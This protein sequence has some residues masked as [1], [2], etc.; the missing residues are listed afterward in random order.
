MGIK[1]KYSWNIQKNE[2]EEIEKINTTNN[3]NYVKY[4]DEKIIKEESKREV[5][6]K[7]KYIQ[8]C[9]TYLMP[10][11]ILS[12]VIIFISFLYIE[13]KYIDL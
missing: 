5:D 9:I 13:I 11:I 7:S 10:L 4:I 2:F 3:F 6:Y 12:I 8:Y 1:K